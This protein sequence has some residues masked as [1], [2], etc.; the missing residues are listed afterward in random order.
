MSIDAMKQ[1]LHVFKEI[2]EGLGNVKKNDAHKD[3]KD[4]A[5]V[6]RKDCNFAM[7]DLTQA[8]AEAEKQKPVAWYPVATAPAETE[9]FIGAYIDGEWKFGR[10]VLFYEQANEF[11]GET[12]SGWVWA[13]DDCDTS[14]TEEPTHWMPLPPPPI[15]AKLREKNG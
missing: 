9:V 3:A 10:S 13:V 6:V 15:E 5:T 11:A 14:V 2:Y 8:I 4:L 1:A 12:F 7:R